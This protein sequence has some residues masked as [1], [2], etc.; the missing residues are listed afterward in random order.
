[1]FT[2][3]TFEYRKCLFT[4]IGRGINGGTNC[5]DLHVGPYQD[6]NKYGNQKYKNMPIILDFFPLAFDLL[7]HSVW[8][9]LL[10]I[11]LQ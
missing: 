5:I 1:M 6:K 3:Q 2:N 4:D 7:Y 11:R 10:G 8:K 9:A